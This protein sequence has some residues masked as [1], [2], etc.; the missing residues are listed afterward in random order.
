M[1]ERI[2]AQDVSSYFNCLFS[3]IPLP[4]VR[5]FCPPPPTTLQLDLPCGAGGD[6]ESRL[7][8]RVSEE[9][10]RCGGWLLESEVMR[11]AGRRVEERLGPA[12]CLGCAYPVSLN[13]HVH[14][15]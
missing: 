11:V 4:V 2:F 10:Y 14:K 8:K 7:A 12:C 5:Q 6:R 9:F 1:R 13:V 15:A 3:A